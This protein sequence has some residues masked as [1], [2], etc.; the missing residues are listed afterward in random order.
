[1]GRKIRKGRVITAAALT[2]A[3]ATT[4][5]ISLKRNTDNNADK[6]L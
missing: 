6:K 1:M 5:V 4:G 3:I 2:I